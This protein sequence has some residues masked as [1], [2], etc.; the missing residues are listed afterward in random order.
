MVQLAR[1][2]PDFIT[3]TCL[4]WKPVLKNDQFKDIII[5]SLRFLSGKIRIT[6]Y[7]FVI[8][9]NH[10]HLLRQIIGDHKRKAVQR[11]FLKYTGQPVLKHLRNSSSP[12][13]QELLVN[14][15]DSKYQ[16]WERNSLTSP[17]WTTK[18]MWQK[19]ILRLLF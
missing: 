6:V 18:A 15:K 5:E 16:V 9:V 8:M 14:S 2:Y 3:T 17:L 7:G 13:L 11:D 4:E 10:F 12:L 1:Q 19:R